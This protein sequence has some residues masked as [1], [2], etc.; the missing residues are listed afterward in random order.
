MM[1]NEERGCW[2]LV[3]HSKC[4]EHPLR[5]A[6]PKQIL[7]ASILFQLNSSSVPLEVGTPKANPHS[8]FGSVNDNTN[9][10]T[11]NQIVADKDN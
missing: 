2:L 9:N 4:Y 3:L 10:E 5:V 7:C 1:R 6:N 11:K 8:F